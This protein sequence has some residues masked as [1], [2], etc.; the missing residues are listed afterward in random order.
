MKLWH[1]AKE[2]VVAGGSSYDSCSFVG[3]EWSGSYND[4]RKEASLLR[5]GCDDWDDEN[6]TFYYAISDVEFKKDYP[7]YDNFP[8]LVKRKVWA[9]FGQE[10]MSDGNWG[11]VLIR[12]SHDYYDLMI[13]MELQKTEGQYTDMHIDVYK[14]VHEE[15]EL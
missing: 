9:L 14:G 8:P 1:V 12:K 4:C 2:D 11:G 6:S 15:A 5:K 7:Y 13:D 10:Y 3:V